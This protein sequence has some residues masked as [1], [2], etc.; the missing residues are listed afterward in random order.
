M[1]KINIALCVGR[2]G[3]VVGIE[4]PWNLI[5][6]SEN[7][8]DL[9]VYYRGGEQIL[10]LYIYH[11]TDKK[12]LFNDVSE[13]GATPNI[14][15]KIYHLICHGLKN[16]G[17]TPE[18]IFYYIYAVLYSN[19][20]REKYAEFLRVDFPRIP[21][22]SNYK[23]FIELGEIGKDLSEIHLMESF[24]LDKT[25][26][27]F[28]VKGDK[29]VKKIKYAETEKRVY[30]NENQYFSNIDKEIWEYQ[31]GGYQVMS[32]WLK[33]RKNRKLSMEDIQHYIKIAR[34][35]QLTIEYQE[36]IDDLYPGV[37]ESLIS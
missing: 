33:D 32:K 1:L 17:I 24:K 6:V 13:Q 37:E 21:F 18:E 12:S 28:D 8:V 27:R 26:S 3:N 36:I 7:I 14:D 5:L 23:L 9:N 25:F 16:K 10:P 15:P 4:R 35:L 29:I 31:I 34:A 19:V 22:T 11:E 20:Y 2:S 30:I